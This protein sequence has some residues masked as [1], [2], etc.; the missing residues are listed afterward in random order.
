M[1]IAG[2]IA[3]YNPFHSGHALHISVTRAKVGADAAVVCVMSGSFVQRGEPAIL[4]KRA[5]AE[6]AL[7][8]GA[9]LV[10]ENPTPWATASAE[11]FAAGG[12]GVLCALNLPA[13]LSFGSEC[14]DLDALKK[15]ADLLSAPAMREAVSAAMKAGVSYASAR[16]A[17]LSAVYREGA[18]L[19]RGPNNILGI[20]YLKAIASLKADKIEP[21]TFA[22]I[23]TEHDGAQSGSLA[24]ASRLRELI[25][26]G[27]DVSAFMPESAFSVL[28]REIEAGL[29]PADIL[30]IESA[31]LYRLR[32]MTDAEYSSLPDATEGLWRRLRDAGA[33]EA[34]LEDVKAAVKTKRYALSRIRRMTVSSV[35]GITAEMQSGL[36]PY[37]RVL[38][39][40]ERGREVLRLA[41]HTAK[42]PI[43]TK[44]AAAK[45][46]SPEAR[47]IFNADVRASD[48]FRLSLPEPSNRKG[49]T[50]WL[51]G[52]VIVK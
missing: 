2:I 33:R 3:E 34:T 38:G 24:P 14:G 37:I 19:L 5:R 17:A 22:R 31:I 21:L 36:P 27:D 15:C 9:D 18:E 46:L 39:L 13:V 7:S 8:S 1:K 45:L 10:L 16:E 42:L 26:A 30:R 11:R 47:A 49:G 51:E 52:P 40:N 4:S 6:M 41:R 35:L 28:R 43:I 23:A 12:V 48:L 44:P 25:R 50:E 29:A 20:E 32:T